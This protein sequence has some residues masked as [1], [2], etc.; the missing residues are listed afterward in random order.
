MKICAR[1]TSLREIIFKKL[2]NSIHTKNSFFN[3][4]ISPPTFTWQV[5]HTVLLWR[6]SHLIPDI[7]SQSERSLG[8]VPTQV[9]DDPSSRLEGLEEDEEIKVD[10]DRQPERQ[11]HNC[12]SLSQ[13]V[14]YGY[15]LGENNS[16]IVPPPKHLLLQGQQMPKDKIRVINNPNIGAK[17][18]GTSKQ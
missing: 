4:V 8:T 9:R 14:S 17:N 3:M 18:H 12:D 11:I 5:Q 15:R 1:K 16:G 13:P 10:I 6:S 7:T 2:Y